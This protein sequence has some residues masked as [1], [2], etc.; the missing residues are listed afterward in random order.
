MK[1]W[2]QLLVLL[3]MGCDGLT[4]GR[5]EGGGG[6]LGGFVDFFGEFG[7]LELEFEDFF[8]GFLAGGEDLVLDADGD[9]EQEEGDAQGHGSKGFGG[10]G[11]VLGVHDHIDDHEGEQD[12]DGGGDAGAESAGRCWAA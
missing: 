8:F 11:D 1:M 5:G 2:V 3:V 6:A 9:Q 4:C 7:D 12:A 10:V